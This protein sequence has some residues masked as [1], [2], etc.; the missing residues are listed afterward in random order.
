MIFWPWRETRDDVYLGTREPDELECQYGFLTE[1]PPFL[2]V[3]MPLNSIIR[4][5]IIIHLLGL[6]PAGYLAA[7]DKGA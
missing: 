4:I 6:A 5:V 7:P 1:D 2:G 3:M